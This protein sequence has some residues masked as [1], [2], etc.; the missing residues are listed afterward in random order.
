MIVEVDNRIFLV[1]PVI[2]D[3]FDHNFLGKNKYEVSHRKH[4][5]HYSLKQFFW[6]KSTSP[7][8]DKSASIFPVTITD[9]YIQSSPSIM[10]SLFSLDSRTSFLQ[11]LPAPRVVDA[12]VLA[13][14]RLGYALAKFTSMFATV[15][16]QLIL[17]NH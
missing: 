2:G 6:M 10:R 12:T 1:N 17:L 16:W 4:N 13:Q 15:P 7:S 5:V 3:A 14:A 11:S 9:V 8:I